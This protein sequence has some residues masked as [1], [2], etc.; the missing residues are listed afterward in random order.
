MQDNNPYAPPKAD[1]SDPVDDAR[2]MELASRGQR[3]ANLLIDTIGY[4]A[5]AFVLGVG[6]AIVNPAALEG[7]T[8]A[9]EWGVRH[10][11][12]GC[13][14]SAERSR[15]RTD[16][17]EADHAHS[18]GHRSRGSTD[19]APSAR[20]HFRAARAVRTV[21]ILR[22]SCYRLARHLVGHS[23]HSHSAAVMSGSGC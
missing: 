16:A 23:G 8:T 17:R 22:S 19:G 18:R 1:V 4:Y 9:G 10:R 6:I 13:I 14:L 12:A 21:F 11:R 20:T 3:F 2:Q 7:L 15:L 5:L